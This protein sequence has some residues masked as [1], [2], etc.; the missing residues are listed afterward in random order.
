MRGL[1]QQASA[2]NWSAASSVLVSRGGEDAGSGDEQLGGRR[3]G[4]VDAAAAEATALRCMVSSS[5]PALS[6]ASLAVGK[7]FRA[8]RVDMGTG[9]ESTREKNARNL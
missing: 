3:Q 1:L 5:S 8:G 7:I 4:A 9:N 6:A 2:C